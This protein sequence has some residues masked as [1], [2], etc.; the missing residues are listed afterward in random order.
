VLWT[1]LSWFL[2]LVAMPFCPALFSAMVC[3]LSS[4]LPTW[5]IS[6]FLLLPVPSPGILKSCPCLLCPAI[7]CWHLSLPTRT[8]WGQIPR[9]YLQT[10]W[11]KQYQNIISIYNTCSHSYHASFFQDGQIRVPKAILG[12]EGYTLTAF[13]LLFMSHF[14]IVSKDSNSLVT[15]HSHDSSRER[16]WQVE[17]HR[18]W[19]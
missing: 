14:Q 18:M 8:N 15:S 1:L 17:E 9:S 16:D 7:G 13:P 10:L 4:I 5:Q 2:H 11:Y 19:Y 3:L 6:A 12:S